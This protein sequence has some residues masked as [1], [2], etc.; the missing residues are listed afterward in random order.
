MQISGAWRL[1][2]RVF[3]P[4]AVGYYL[5]YLYR[6]INALIASRLSSDT[7]LGTADL[8]LLTSVYFLVFAAAQIPVGISLDRFG[9]RRVQSVLLLLA[10]VGA[11]L[12]AVSTG[13]LS[14]LI[15]RAM[16]GL[17]LAAALTA[18]LKSMIL[19][20]PRERVALLNGYMVMLG[21]LGAVTA[22]APVEHLLAWMGWRQLFEVLAAATGVTAALIYVV[23]PERGIVSSMASTPA[24]LSSVFGDCRFWRMAPLSATCIGSAWSLQGLWASL[25]LADVEGLDR[26]SLVRQ[27][28]MM[29][30]VLSG[31]AWLFGMTVHC[32]K[33]RGIG[34]ETVLALVAALFIAAEFALILRAPLPS[35]LPWSVVAIV[36]T[37]TV[38]SFAVILD[39]FPPELAGRANGALNVLHFGWAFLAQYATGLILEQWSAND[40]RRPVQAYQVAFGL[41]IALQIAALVWFALPWRRS[42]ASWISSIVFFE[43][44]DVSYAVETVRLY[45]DSVILLPA[46]DDAEW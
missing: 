4:F 3:L 9:P 6:T 14:L 40:G 7:G 29:S 42:V 23:V 44:T 16:I 32:I 17:G 31:G 26:A 45:E 24:T 11:W 38:V 13:F 27:L 10:A 18:G 35:V 15:A 41:Y 12:F 33:R 37:A 28:F 36:G 20:F 19:W 22:T 5:S 21:S 2:A 1:T 46:D 34:A 25:W 43:P 39:Y 30:I 8:G